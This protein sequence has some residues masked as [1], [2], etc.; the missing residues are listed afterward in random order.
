MKP[1]DSEIIRLAEQSGIEEMI[2]KDLD[3][4]LVNRSEVLVELAKENDEPSTFDSGLCQKCG[5]PLTKYSD[6]FS[7]GTGW[8]EQKR[9]I[10]TL[11]APKRT[12]YN[13]PEFARFVESQRV[14][15]VCGG[16]HDG[17]D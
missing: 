9:I 17:L 6:C 13:S 11:N 5:E 15:P 4:G 12:D 7:C 1:T 10:D 8:T 14:F 3:G 16:F 2:V